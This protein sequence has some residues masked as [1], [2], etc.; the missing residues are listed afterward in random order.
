MALG[1]SLNWDKADGD[2]QVAHAV[3]D[4]LEDR[5]ILFANSHVENEV[6]CVRSANAARE[7][8]TDQLSKAKPGKSLAASLKA[9]RTSF[10]RFVEA[11]GDDGRNFR[12]SHHFGDIDGLSL[13]LGELRG[14]VGL[15]V[16]Y[17]AYYYSLE[18]EG[19]LVEILPSFAS[20]DD[21]DLSKP[22]QLH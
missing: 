16:A 10:R 12:Y 14:Q 19:E 4:F 5:R 22:P 11:A 21:D 2:K 17:I 8:L 18:V 15:H 1:F 20:D 3:L 7:F 9:M 6:F 13:A